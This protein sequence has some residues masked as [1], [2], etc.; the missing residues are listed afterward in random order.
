MRVPLLFSTYKINRDMI[1]KRKQTIQKE[2]A[3][4]FIGRGPAPFRRN[5]KF[6]GTNRRGPKPTQTPSTPKIEAPVTPSIS[7]P[8]INPSENFGFDLSGVS[9][10]TPKPSPMNITGGGNIT[11]YT[12]QKGGG[13]SLSS[14][15]TPKTTQLPKIDSRQVAQDAVKGTGFESAVMGVKKPI[16]TPTPPPLPAPSGSTTTTTTTTTNTNNTGGKSK[17]KLKSAA[18]WGLGGLGTVAAGGL[19]IPLVAANSEYGIHDV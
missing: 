10:N 8:K 2:F 3:K 12:P 18:K 14:D 7:T 16:Q 17:N 9:F 4:P 1:V 5:S 19:A 6:G 13:M 15:F 11:T